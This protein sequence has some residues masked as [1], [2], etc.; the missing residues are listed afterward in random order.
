MIYKLVGWPVSGRVASDCI[1][2]DTKLAK[3]FSSLLACTF[4]SLASSAAFAQTLDNDTTELEEIVV[5][6][7]GEPEAKLPLGIGISGS[8]LTNAPGSGG[9]PVRTLQSLPGLAFTNDEEALPAV[10]GS[11][12]GDNYFQAD[13]AP[14]NYL[15]HLG[16]V[17]S[18]FNTDLIKTFNVYQSAY[19]PE[20]SGVT[21]GVFD[22]ELREPKNDRFRSTVDISFLHAGVVIEGPVTENQAFYLAGRVSYL[23]LLLADQIPEEDGIKIEK[24]PKYSDY[25]GKYV[26]K[27]SE[28]NSLTFQI[29]GAADTA[30]IEVAEDSIEIETDPIVAGTIFFDTR[31]HEQA[32]MWDT[33]VTNKLEV[34]TLLSHT[35]A[36][37]EGKFGGVG[38][39][40]V[41]SDGLFLKT[42]ASYALSD[43]HDLIVGAQVAR[44][45]VDLDLALS[46]PV[47]GELDAD[48][49]LTGSERLTSQK[50]FNF[51]GIRAYVKDNW[52]VTDKL[53]LYPGLSFQSED[54]L[55]KQF[56]EPRMALEY[57]LSDDTILSAGVGQYQQA[58]DYLE[59]D[60]VFG[61]PDIEYTNALHAQV[62]VQRI[63]DGGW[64]VK[65]ELYYKSLDNLVT[66]DDILDYTN[67]GEGY[68][69]GLDTLIRKDLSNKLSGWA[70]ISLSK[71]RRKDKRTGET[72]VFEYDQPINVSLVG[73]YK[74]NEKWSFG[75]KLWVHSGAPVTPVIGATEDADI[76][77]F[78]RPQ[79][80]KLNSSRFPTYHRVDLRIDRAF[81]RKKDNTM[82]A[83]ID[84]LNVLGTENAADYDYNADYTE[85]TIAPQLVGA[86]S[87]GFKATF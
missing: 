87:L 19:G 8:T 48:C 85:K 79:Y 14:I 49:I 6:E 2:S 36:V 47:C 32:L 61:N 62:G 12:P 69:Y 51:T 43:N 86:V 35:N 7:E 82:T 58:P 46:L 74:L 63:F 64:D 52:Y 44:E 66:S 80:G 39:I 70:S 84:I 26:W 37:E 38:E 34:K 72:F 50:K 73:Q 83:Y 25:Q 31:S 16:G 13:F 23:D 75:S 33:K 1:N 11:R 81:K 27:P 10:R 9:D 24:F 54:L 53:T 76:P 65:S 59:S 3:Q 71:A 22:V 28:D 55:D 67:D 68:A 18:V 45:K 17:I 60:D 20:F 29:N 21:G 56:I 15:F 40:Y 57:S 77:G 4:L 42:R 41:E 78:Y 30:Q 5:E